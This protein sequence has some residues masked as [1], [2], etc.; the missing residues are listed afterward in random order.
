MY[1]PDPRYS[2]ITLV[3]KAERTISV[4]STTLDVEVTATISHTLI[5]DLLFISD[6][7]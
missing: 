2:C 6:I 1:A 4:V 5:A 7:L 3:V